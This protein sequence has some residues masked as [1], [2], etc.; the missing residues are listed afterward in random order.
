MNNPSP[1]KPVIDTFNIG[2]AGVTFVG[3]AQ[4]PERVKDI[5]Y[6]IFKKGMV[7]S[8]GPGPEL[9]RLGED[10]VVNQG[11]DDILNDGV[12]IDPKSGQVYSEQ[13]IAKI[14]DFNGSPLNQEEKV[15]TTDNKMDEGVKYRMHIF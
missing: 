8:T 5:A 9:I 1:C 3:T 7:E 6:K 2:G 13:S 14:T 4:A 10:N 12:I 15:L 11:W